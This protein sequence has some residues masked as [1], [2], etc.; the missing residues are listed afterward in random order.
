M[1]EI[2][3]SASARIAVQFLAAA[4]LSAVLVVVNPSSAGAT[5]LQTTLL[6]PINGRITSNPQEPHH[7]PW[8]G[9]YAW[10]V[11]A[12]AGTPVYANFR[13]TSGSLSL[14]AEGVFEPCAAPNQGKGGQG[15]KVGVYVNGTRLGHIR[16]VHLRNIPTAS[17]AISP[18]ARIGDVSSG[19]SSSCWTGSHV[20]VEPRN[21]VRYSCY[22]A[23]GLGA[24]VNTGT[25]LGVFG[26]EWA[27]AKNRSCPS[28]AEYSPP[29]PP[30]VPA[31]RYQYLSQ[32]FYTDATKTKPKSLS[33]LVP[34]DRVFVVLTVR[35]TGSR[36][37]SRGGANPVRL[38]TWQPQ[39]RDSRFRDSTWLSG[40]RPATLKQSSVAP[41]ANGTF[42]LWVNVPTGKGTFRE[43][44]NVVAEH[45][46]WLPSNGIYW[47]F[48][49][50]K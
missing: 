46:A 35:N 25:R 29:P 19:S 2:K 7:T 20:H 32:A 11:A 49:V 34:G 50:V 3:H 8:D 30:A 24:T 27:T 48:K 15:L 1:N 22:F 12:G 43:H 41:G 42:E 4:V 23:T 6:S 36:T 18:G 9:D 40:S 44:F 47:D 16:Y 33:N 17:G 38:G 31:W 14:V 10:D 37:W 45:A 26:G 13:N 39:D 5:T 28:N 21:D